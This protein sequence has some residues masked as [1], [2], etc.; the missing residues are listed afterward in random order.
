MGEELGNKAD[1]MSSVR[2]S[3]V[4][5]EDCGSWMV[6]WTAILGEEK[7]L[8]REVLVAAGL[9]GVG[10][11]RGVE[12]SRVES[13]GL[14]CSL[15]DGR[16]GEPSREDIVDE[17]EDSCSPTAIPIATGAEEPLNQELSPPFDLS[18]TLIVPSLSPV[19]VGMK[20]TCSCLFSF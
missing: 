11:L 4:S 10:L 2:N 7:K 14:F 18:A 5:R 6:F 19:S 20:S 16:S 3:S 13:V 12:E 1:V 15:A 9:L 8:K 17:L